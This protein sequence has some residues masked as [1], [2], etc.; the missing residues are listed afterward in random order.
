M[1]R[2]SLAEEGLLLDPFFDQFCPEYPGFRFTRQWL[3]SG[4]RTGSTWPKEVGALALPTIM[5]FRPWIERLRLWAL[6]FALRNLGLAFPSLSVVCG[7]D[8]GLWVW[9]LRS[10]IFIK[11]CHLALGPKFPSCW[12][13][14]R[15][16]RNRWT[17]SSW[18]WGQFNIQGSANLCSQYGCSSF[19]QRASSSY[20]QI[21]EH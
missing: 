6:G 13:V 20:L 14:Y 17:S 5:E 7:W 12:N 16:Q 10:R 4:L 19:M 21:L 1:G 8:L 3:C 9:A 15:N 2:R 11:P 18:S